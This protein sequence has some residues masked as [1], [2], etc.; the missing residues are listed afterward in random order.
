MVARPFCL[1]PITSVLIQNTLLRPPPC[2]TTSITT[3]LSSRCVHHPSSPLRSCRSTVE[4]QVLTPHLPG[5]CGCVPHVPHAVLCSPQERPRRHQGYVFLF[6]EELWPGELTTKRTGRPCKIVE[7]STSKT[8]KHGH[9]KVH[10][11]AID[12]SR[13][14]NTR[15]V[16]LTYA[17]PDLH[18]KKIGTLLTSVRKQ[19][20]VGNTS[21]GGYLSLHPQHGCPQRLP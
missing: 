14:V 11:V 18:G 21:T 8:G 13:F 12:V 6:L 17:T 15:S 2:L 7:M 3:R 1:L 16:C 10:L 20:R 5:L 4:D 9:A 19:I